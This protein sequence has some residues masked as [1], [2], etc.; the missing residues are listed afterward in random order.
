MLTLVPRIHRATHRIGLYL[1]SLDDFSLSQG[2]AHILALL[3]MSGPTTIAELHRGLAHK[4]STLTSILDRLEARGLVTRNV[5]TDDRR[6]FVV[7]T[8]A[9]GRKVSRAVLQHLTELERAV[10]AH[11]SN[12]DLRAFLKVIEAV[13]D[14]AHRRVPSPRSGT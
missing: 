9:R 11:L 4:R 10:K 3:A 8:T 7:A 2:E 6:T 5:G 1:A 13:E 14:E 12:E